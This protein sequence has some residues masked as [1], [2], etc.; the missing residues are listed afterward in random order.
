M[1]PAVI[2]AMKEFLIH[3]SMY[4]SS[5]VMFVC[6]LFSNDLSYNFLQFMYSIVLCSIS[7]NRN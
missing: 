5:W 2:D 1:M 6:R 4:Q 3:E 7:S